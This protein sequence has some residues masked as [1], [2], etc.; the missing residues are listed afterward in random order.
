[1]ETL[2]FRVSGVRL[3]SNIQ[4]GDGIGNRV[5]GQVYVAHNLKALSSTSIMFGLRYFGL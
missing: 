1:M 2:S 5:I 4:D 3:Q